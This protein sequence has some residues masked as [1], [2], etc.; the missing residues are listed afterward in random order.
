M[1]RV[2]AQRNDQIIVS[3][4]EV[5][6]TYKDGVIDELVHMGREYRVCLCIDCLPATRLMLVGLLRP[7]SSSRKIIR[8]EETV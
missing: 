5:S 1:N 7:F 3:V 2:T 4:A 8:H 6:W